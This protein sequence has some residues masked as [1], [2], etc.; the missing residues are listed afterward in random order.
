VTDGLVSLVEPARVPI[1]MCTWRRVERL[2][3]TLELLAEQDTPASL[4]IWNNNRNEATR[5]DELLAR[6]AVP[7]QSVHCSRNIGCFGRFYLAR[8]LAPAHEA[9]LFIDDDQDFGRTMVTD[10]LASFAPASLAGWWAFDYRPGAR[11]YAERD[12]VDEPGSSADYVG[13]GGMVADAS[14]FADPGLFGCPRRYWFVD[15]LWLSYYASEVRGW[16][17]RRSGA[18]FRFAADGR[19][20]DLTLWI[21][22][23]RMFRYLKRRG[24]SVA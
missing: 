24:W 11:S 9:V 12:R 22:K 19:D 15:D 23:V 18:E 13:V 1:V 6:G 21:T 20:I 8:E 17:L 3:R 2:P 16:D 5:I 14:I 7:A 4:Y 10:Q